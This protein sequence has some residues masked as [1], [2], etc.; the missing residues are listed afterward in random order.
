MITHIPI[1][2]VTKIKLQIIEQ[3]HSHLAA[4]LY[5][6]RIHYQT[7]Y[8]TLTLPRSQSLHVW[9]TV[10]LHALSIYYLYNVNKLEIKLS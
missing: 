1:I 4:E 2:S 5:Y 8:T 6:V 9:I 7:A 3:I 10:L